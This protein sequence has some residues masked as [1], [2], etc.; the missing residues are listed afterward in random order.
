MK[1]KIKILIADDNA[2]FISTLLTYFENQ[3]DMEVIS[4]AKD[5]I[6]AVEKISRFTPRCCLIRYNYATT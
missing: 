4:T 1:D 3:D 2:E 6:E 5:G